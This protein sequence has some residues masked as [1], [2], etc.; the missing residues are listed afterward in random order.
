MAS[1]FDW[2]SDRGVYRAGMPTRDFSGLR[3]IVM[4]GHM[5]RDHEAK[6]YFEALV[7]VLDVRKAFQV[8]HNRGRGALLWHSLAW[9]DELRWVWLVGAGPSGVAEL[10]R[11]AVVQLLR[12][13]ARDATGSRPHGQRGTQGPTQAQ[14]QV[15]R[16]RRLPGATPRLLASGKRRW[17]LVAVRG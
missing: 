9:A 15:L 10:R 5:L 1:L 17:R 14:L 6:A 11:G 12:H 2:C 4:A 16:P 7:E 3:R 8:R 13:T